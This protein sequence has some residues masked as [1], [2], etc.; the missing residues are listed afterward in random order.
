MRYYPQSHHE[1]MKKLA[2]EYAQAMIAVNQSTL[3]ALKDIK[4]SQE[5]NQVIA[6]SEARSHILSNEYFYN[7]ERELA[8]MPKRDTAIGELVDSIKDVF[9]RAVE[10]RDLVDAINRSMED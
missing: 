1:H 3:K 6:A 7:V 10:K 2:I 8:I 5:M 9:E 4:D